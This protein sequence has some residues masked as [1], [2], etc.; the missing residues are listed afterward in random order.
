MQ[1]KFEKLKNYLQEQDKQGVCLAFSGGIDSL[2]LLY[3][4]KN[5][6]MTTVTLDSVFQDEEDIIFTQEICR[7]W[8]IKQHIIDYSPL[9]EETLAN[10]PADRCYYCKKLFFGKIKTYAEEQ[11]LEHII[12]GTNFDDL[13]EYRPGRKALEE[14]GIISPFAEFKITKKEIRDYARICGIECYD[15]PS[16]PCFATRFPYGDLITSENIKKVKLCEKFLKENGFSPCRVRLH[17][18]IA[19]IEILP[20]QFEKFLSK[21]D[22]IIKSFKETGIIYITLDLE[23][24]RS[25][26][27][28][29][30]LK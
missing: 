3:L 5:L 4:C 17:N 10:N 14:L 22:L 13:K 26:S 18:D 20:K 27:M 8:E 12:D 6:N 24:Y 7:R 23:G 11:G 28:D 29:I 1:T 16:N 2:L 21:K 19:R 25:G 30:A 15:K 9:K